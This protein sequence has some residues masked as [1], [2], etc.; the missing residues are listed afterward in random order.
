MKYDVFIRPGSQL[1]NIMFMYAFCSYYAMKHNM[2][3]YIVTDGLK[4][5][6]IDQYKRTHIFNKMNV[7][8]HYNKDYFT[9][10]P[11]TY[12]REYVDF[13]H[14]PCCNI[15]LDGLF[16]SPKYWNNDKNFCMDLFY[17]N[18][19]LIDEIKRIYSDIDFNNTISIHMRRTDFFSYM[20]KYVNTIDYINN[21]IERYVDDEKTFII[22]SDDIQWCKHNMKDPRF[23]FAERC[24]EKY[25]KII[26]DMFIMTLCKGNIVNNASTFS[27]WGSY[28]NNNPGR[29][30]YY[31]SKNMKLFDF[32]PENDGWVDTCF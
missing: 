10:K 28:L 3:P 1:G 21:I 13:S 23:V 17:P 20:K 11:Q 19:D 25:P 30:V 6:W 22:L 24:S 4:R 14:T 31:S 8:D 9:I 18:N 32:I 29:K 27:W 12:S 7:I 26:I 5:I 15:K 16:Q 2:T